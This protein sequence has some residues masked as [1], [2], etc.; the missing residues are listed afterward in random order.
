MK[1]AFEEAAAF[2]LADGFAAISA[3]LMG[4]P[5]KSKMPVW[6]VKYQY[7]EVLVDFTYHHCDQ[8]VNH[9]T[10]NLKKGDV[11]KLREEPMYFMPDRSN[12]KFLGNVTHIR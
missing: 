2:C 6:R 11:V 10:Y 9:G 8:D 5:Y 3:A 7:Y 1:S 4:V 12:M